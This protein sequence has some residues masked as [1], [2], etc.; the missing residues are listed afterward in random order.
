MYGQDE[1]KI[2]IPNNIP[3]KNFSKE[4]FQVLKETCPY[5]AKDGINNTRGCC[6]LDQL[7]NLHVSLKQASGL[8]SRCPSCSKNFFDMFCEFTCSP[9]QSK[10]VD[11]QMYFGATYYIT[12]NFANG[13]FDSC[14]DVSFPGSNSKVMDMMCGTTAKLCTKEKFLAF[15]G[16]V[17]SGSPFPISFKIDANLTGTN[18]T[19]NNFK[20]YGCNETFL[21]DSGRNS[22][23]CSCQDCQPTC[24]IIPPPPKPAEPKYIMGIKL[25][26]FIT[27][28]VLLVWAIIF[29][30][31]SVIEI[32]RTSKNN[33]RSS[34]RSDIIYSNTNSSSSSNMDKSSTT[35]LYGGSG[36]KGRWVTLGIK[37]EETLQNL[38]H[39]WGSL[40]AF[41]PWKVILGSLV[42]V[43]VLSLGLLKFTI[44]T[45]P[46]DLWASTDS[47]ARLEKQYFDENFAP[48]YRTEQ[49]ILTSTVDL[50]VETYHPYQSVT[51]TNFSGMINLDVFNKVTEIHI[52]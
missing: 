31:F 7:N 24:P 17:N 5:L 29:L 42:F 6:A 38:F 27:G 37:A 25:C 18:F 4:A 49:V 28:I 41:N 47:K 21:L 26:S 12:E 20:M 34:K 9:N 50:P 11:Y 16:S 44:V 2:P 1:N 51:K 45:D 39:K 19:S 3:A 43:L 13:L 15:V 48:F 33:E 8:F 10:F 23:I 35:A 22:T 30:A 36:N 52:F 32:F 14:K 40:C 46:V